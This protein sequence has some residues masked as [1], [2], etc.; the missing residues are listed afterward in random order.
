LLV[1]QQQEVRRHWILG[2][3]LHQL[4]GQRGSLTGRGLCKVHVIDVGCRGRGLSLGDRR[5]SGHEAL[6]KPHTLI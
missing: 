1:A 2:V 3:L 5:A 4:G 6:R